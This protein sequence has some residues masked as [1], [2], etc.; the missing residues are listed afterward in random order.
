MHEQFATIYAA[1]ECLI[2]MEIAPWS[3]PEFA[4]AL[5]LCEASAA[6]AACKAEAC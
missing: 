1:G 3:R 6:K 4:Q 2:S 5:L